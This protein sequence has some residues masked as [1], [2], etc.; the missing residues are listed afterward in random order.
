MIAG[1]VSVDNDNPLM[2]HLLVA[3][4]VDPLSIPSSIPS[5]VHIVKQQV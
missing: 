4:G 1:A 2:T 3:N 5:R